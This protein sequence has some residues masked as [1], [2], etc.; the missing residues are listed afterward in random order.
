MKNIRKTS[1][2]TAKL[3]QKVHFDRSSKSLKAPQTAAK[4]SAKAPAKK[5]ENAPRWRR[6]YSNDPDSQYLQ[7]SEIDALFRVIKSPR[8]TAIFRIIYHR[9]LRS[10]EP[11][12]LQLSDWNEREGTLYVRRGKRSISRDQFLNAIERAAIRAWLKVRGHEPGPLF[13]SAHGPRAGGA[14]LSLGIH[15]NRLDELFRQYCRAAGIRAEKAHMHVLKHSCGTHLA[16]RGE[17][18][19]MIQDYLG[20]RAAKS[21]AIY[22]HFSQRRRREAAARLEHWK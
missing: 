21:T 1:K 5:A 10:S 15:R 9:G 3:G 12:Q 17:S 22:M 18:A 19:D 2:N 7:S 4:T 6:S 8:D 20:H 11:G 14:G 13:P 16:E